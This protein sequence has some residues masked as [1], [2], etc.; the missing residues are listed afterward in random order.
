MALESACLQEFCDGRRGAA[1][2]RVERNLRDFSGVSSRERTH[3]MKVGTR[4]DRFWVAQRGPEDD[5]A[6]QAALNEADSKTVVPR[7]GDRGFE[8][9]PLR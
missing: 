3:V 8:S 7:L 4:R 5:N 1:A 6:Q 9:H 2:P